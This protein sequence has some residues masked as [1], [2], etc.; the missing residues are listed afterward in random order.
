MYEKALWR[1]ND[2]RTRDTLSFVLS[3]R[4][5]EF[6]NPHHVSAVYTAMFTTLLRSI[7]HNRQTKQFIDSDKITELNPEAIS[8][9]FRN[10][11]CN[12]KGDDREQDQTRHRKHQPRNFLVI[13]LQDPLAI[14]L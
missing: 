9:C 8:P 11:Y 1:P 7:V 5:V 12:L 13:V 3:P 14:F 4:C 6:S 2:S 10:L